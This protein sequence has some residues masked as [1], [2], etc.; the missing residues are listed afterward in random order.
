MEVLDQQVGGPNLARDSA[1]PGRWGGRR[2][3]EGG[4][5]KEVGGRRSGLEAEGQADFAVTLPRRHEQHEAL[6]F[7]LWLKRRHEIAN[8]RKRPQSPHSG[9]ASSPSRLRRYV[10]GATCR[11][12]CQALSPVTRQTPPVAGPVS[13]SSRGRRSEVRTRAGELQDF[14]CHVALRLKR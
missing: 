11:Q 10:G 1:P 5:R 8:T 14:R 3:E 13:D 12:A 4:R 6:G 2:P 9:F 7:R